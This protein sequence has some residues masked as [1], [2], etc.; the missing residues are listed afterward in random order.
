[1]EATMSKS[2]EVKAL[3]DQFREMGRIAAEQMLADGEQINLSELDTRPLRALVFDA[4]EPMAKD[5]EAVA[6]LAALAQETLFVELVKAFSERVLEL[7]K[8]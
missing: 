5:V 3:V 4:I 6:L 7:R 2:D 8:N 1:M